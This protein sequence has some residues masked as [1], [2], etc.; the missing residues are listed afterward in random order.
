MH[1]NFIQLSTFRIL[2]LNY[3]MIIF[4]LFN[5]CEINY[6]GMALSNI[7]FFQNIFSSKI[8]QDVQKSHLKVANNWADRHWSEKKLEQM[9]S[10]DWRIFKEDF[11]LSSKGGKVPNP[12][13]SWNECPSLTKEFLHLLEDLG[14]D[15]PTAIQKLAIPCAIKN[16]DVIGV[17]ETGSGKTLAFLIPLIVWLMNISD[18]D[19][20]TCSD[21]GP[22]AVILAPTRELVQ[23]I[24]HVR[25]QF[26]FIVK[27]FNSSAVRTVWI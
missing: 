5:K 20:A 1:L 24:H 18:E 3:L 2:Y 15:T 27:Y 10:R 21:D 6:H 13:R 8:L 22:F 9:T 14:Y 17:A 19:R 25:F 7:N 16:R 23:Q 12:L 26:F 4:N 11:D